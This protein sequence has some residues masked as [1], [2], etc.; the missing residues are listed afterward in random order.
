[1]PTEKQ[2][3]SI[4][5]VERLR[6]RIARSLGRALPSV[7]AFLPESAFTRLLSSACAT[8][9]PSAAPPSQPR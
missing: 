2:L 1:M 9:R 8:L 7:I 6:S 4:D 3:R 5:P